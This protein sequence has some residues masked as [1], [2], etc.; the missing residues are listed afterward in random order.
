M[1]TTIVIS[2]RDKKPKTLPKADVCS[3][4][5]SCVEGQE[6][7][8]W[9]PMDLALTPSSPSSAPPQWSDPRQVT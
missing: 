6:R 8:S 5:P 7:C 9:T 1:T 2:I 3:R 4:I